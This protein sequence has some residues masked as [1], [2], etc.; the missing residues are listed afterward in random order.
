LE[1]SDPE[2]YGRRPASSC[3]P[4]LFDEGLRTVLEAALEVVEPQQR[5]RVYQRLQAACERAFKC[6]FPDYGLYGQRRVP[7]LPPTPLAD[8]EHLKQLRDPSS[9]F[10]VADCD[11]EISASLPAPPAKD[12]QEVDVMEPVVPAELEVQ[13]APRTSIEAPASSIDRPAAADAAN[14]PTTPEPNSDPHPTRLPAA[15][16]NR[17]A[18][19][20]RDHLLHR[21]DHR[22]RAVAGA[23][24]KGI[25]SPKMRIR[26]KTHPRHIQN[27]GGP[28]GAPAAGEVGLRVATEHGD[29]KSPERTDG[30]VG[31]AIRVG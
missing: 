28:N 3:S 1:R 29:P 5:S 22:E 23:F 20:T 31:E 14:R 19:P 4:F 13:S 21:T 10:H 2:R 15:S 11:D 9:K 17:V 16:A 24:G 26:D 7:E 8:A 18:R 12:S 6:V 30:N 27:G 25:L